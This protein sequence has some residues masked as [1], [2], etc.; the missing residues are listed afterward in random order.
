MSNI[1]DSLIKDEPVFLRGFGTFLNKVRKAKPA[2][3]IAAKTTI[4]IPEHKIPYFKP[5]KDF[6]NCEASYR[7]DYNGREGVVEL[8]DDIGQLHGT[9]GGLAVIPEEDT[10]TILI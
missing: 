2:R 7:K 3:N 10:F 9:W 1:K 8:I 6:K 5:A 4:V